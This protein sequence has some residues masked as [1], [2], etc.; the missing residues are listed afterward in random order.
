V[1]LSPSGREKRECFIAAR[2]RQS[3]VDR[4]GAIDTMAWCMKTIALFLGLS[5]VMLTSCATAPKEVA[6]V[7]REFEARGVSRVILRASAANRALKTIVIR[8]APFVSVFGTPAGGPRG[9]RS[10]DPRMWGTPS[11]NW[12]L[13]FAARQFG[14]TLMISTRNEVSTTHHRYR[15]E[16]LQIILPSLNVKLVREGRRLTANGAPDLSPP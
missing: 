7:N 6:P 9:Y 13:D 2:T 4:L 12:G 11:S 3:R 15:L 5:T 1:R 10:S 16:Q 14:S 8:D